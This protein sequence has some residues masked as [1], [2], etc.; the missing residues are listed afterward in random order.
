MRK[1][2]WWQSCGPIG[3]SEEEVRRRLVPRGWNTDPFLAD[4]RGCTLQAVKPLPGG[5]RYRCRLFK[6][7]D[8]AYCELEPDPLARPLSHLLGEG[9]RPGGCRGHG[10]F[11][12]QSRL[13]VAMTSTTNPLAPRLAFPLAG[14]GARAVRFTSMSTAACGASVGRGATRLSLRHSTR[15]PSHPSRSSSASPRHSC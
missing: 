3:L 9:R 7:E 6:E 1:E 14:A 12:P 11:T 10:S 5:L 8:R 2:P 4:P 13:A 15:E